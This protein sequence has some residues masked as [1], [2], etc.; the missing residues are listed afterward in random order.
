[1]NNININPGGFIGAIVCGGIAA[2]LIFSLVDVANSR[3]SPFKLIIF[4]IIGGAVG[5]NYLWGNLFKKADENLA[6]DNSTDET[7]E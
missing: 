2:A 4:A 5:G 3:R 1:M 6:D 7:A